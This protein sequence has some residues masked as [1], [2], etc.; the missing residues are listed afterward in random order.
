M[1]FIISI[2]ANSV[3]LYIATSIV[4]GVVVSDNVSWYYFAFAGLMFTVVFS[5][6]LPVIKVISL[7]LIVLTLG[8]FS[9]V[10]NLIAFYALD[11]FLPQIE[12]TTLWSIILTAIVISSINM[13]SNSLLK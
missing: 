13:I 2:I 5:I 3:G 8:F 9:F 4:P 7:P 12:F 11:R 10:L 6:I 1:N